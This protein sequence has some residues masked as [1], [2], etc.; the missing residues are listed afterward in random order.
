[1]TE[2]FIQKAREINQFINDHNYLALSLKE[3]NNVK[4]EILELQK[5]LQRYEIRINEHISIAKRV[6]NIKKGK[7]TASDY[8]Y[9]TSPLAS[10][11]FNE[12]KE[13]KEIAKFKE[14][15]ARN[16]KIINEWIDL[17]W[18]DGEELS[19]NKKSDFYYIAYSYIDKNNEV[20]LAKYLE[21]HISDLNF[22]PTDK[23]FISKQIVVVPL[24]VLACQ[25]GN[26]NIVKMLCKK[27]AKI[28][29]D[30]D[31]FEIVNPDN[32]N[33][34][35]S[36][37]FLPPLLTAIKFKNYYI[38]EFLLEKGGNAKFNDYE[39]NSA[40]HILSKNCN[41]TAGDNKLAIK[42]AKILI[43]KGVQINGLNDC[44][45]TPICYA[46][47]NYKSEFI[48]FMIKSGANIYDV[49]EDKNSILN[50]LLLNYN[51]E[52][53]LKLKDTIAM[54]KFLINIKIDVNRKNNFD[55]TALHYAVRWQNNE[56]IKLLLENTNIN[57][58]EIDISKNTALHIL[59]K[60][61]M[62]KK[63]VD[64]VLVL[65]KVTLLLNAGI[66]INASNHRNWTPL[67]YAICAVN[68]IYTKFLIQK[69]AI[70]DHTN[71]MGDIALNIL[72]FS[73]LHIKNLKYNG[74]LSY[75]EDCKKI[76]LLL[77]KN[78]NLF[79]IKNHNGQTP[80]YFATIPDDSRY[81]KFLLSKKVDVLITD[82]NNCSI[83]EFFLAIC[84]EK[85]KQEIKLNYEEDHKKLTLLIK[86]DIVITND[87]IEIAKNINDITYYQYLK[88]QFQKNNF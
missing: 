44:S 72:L 60:N 73:H 54:I 80:L 19:V 57:I 25:K 5:E 55:K 50:I 53:T 24:L 85:Q 75:D 6:E 13:L 84:L 10:I 3:I 33:V 52:K 46:I 26:I 81:F 27:G 1:M 7:I 2:Y 62:F 86:N 29:S 56:F 20:E 23:R 45:K 12:Q 58:N 67:F 76:E 78:K 30:S 74:N 59:F 11:D 32:G 28:D 40:L 35:F 61:I 79:N 36:D 42:M 68:S 43:E 77:E 18:I 71:N 37:Y 8:W 87:I 4:K 16:L 64:S 83:L 14:I 22:V 21:N 70:S 17:K 39:N 47:N 66:N 31:Y 48:E 34:I 49:D 51:N 63:N 41:N 69:G 15:L 82:N 88:R 9:M 38:A 65:Q